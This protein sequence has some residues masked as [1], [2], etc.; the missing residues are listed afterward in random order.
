MLIN[1]LLEHSQTVSLQRVPSLYPANKREPSPSRFPF[2]SATKPAFPAP[3]SNASCEKT[4]RRD[5]NVSSSGRQSLATKLEEIFGGKAGRG[6]LFRRSPRPETPDVPLRGVDKKT[7]RRGKLEARRLGKANKK[8][9]SPYMRA[10]RPAIT[11]SGWR[12]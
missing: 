8:L 6:R 5:V 4:K 2:E 11:V 7:R 10:R 9:A 1:G 12:E 3:S